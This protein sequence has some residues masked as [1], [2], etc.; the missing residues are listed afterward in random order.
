[1]GNPYASRR[2]SARP[3]PPPIV[4]PE[5]TAKFIL[6]WVSDDM[7][8]ARAALSTERAKNEEIRRPML[9]AA[10]EGMLVTQ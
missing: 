2:T 10:L 8:R 7:P 9:I 4:V 6:D 1:M 3:L 5:G